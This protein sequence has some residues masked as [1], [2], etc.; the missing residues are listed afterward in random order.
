MRVLKRQTVEK[1]TQLL[2]AGQVCNQLWFINQGLARAY[3]FK[4]DKEITS[5]F[6]METDFIISVRSFF[7]QQRSYEYIEMLEPSE[8]VSITYSDLQELY[9]TYSEFNQVGR[10]LTE[11]YYARSEERLFQL[12]M[13]TA[14]ERYDA[15]LMAHP[16]IFQRASLKQIASYLGL[17]PETLSRLRAKR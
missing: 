10:I 5:W 14:Q 12:R 17:T 8:L 6:M 1:K 3:Y 7:G 13:N 4:E 2:Q 15:L 16:T 11:R 9:A